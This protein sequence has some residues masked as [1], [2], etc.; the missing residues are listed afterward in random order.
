ML[1][2]ARYLYGLSPPDNPAVKEIRAVVLPP[3]VGNHQQVILP[4]GL[5]EHE[6]LADLEPLGW[7][8]TQPN[9]LTQ[10]NPA[11]VTQHARILEQHK[12]WDGE[13]CI[14]IT[15]SFTPGSCSLAAYK[16]TPA[17][18]EWGRNNKDSGSNPQ[19]YLPTHYEKVQVRVV[20]LA[21]LLLCACQSL[22]ERM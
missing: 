10:L 18:Y 6:Y 1:L 5:P 14:I 4:A 9:E 3:Q 16:L 12:A 19:G 8:H 11:D 21:C 13:R 7:I 22:K 15:C 2:A 17:G 20:C